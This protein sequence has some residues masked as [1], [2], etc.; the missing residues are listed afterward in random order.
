VSYIDGTPKNKHPKA[1]L[2]TTPTKIHVLTKTDPFTK[3]TTVKT[4]T[5]TT[6]RHYS[7]PK[8]NTHQNKT[9]SPETKA[10]PHPKDHAVATTS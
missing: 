2:K 1:P 8:K 10:E 3:A 5:N 7:P 6:H 4:I 9:L